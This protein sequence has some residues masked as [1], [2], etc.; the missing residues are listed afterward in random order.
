MRKNLKLKVGVLSLAAVLLFS[1]CVMVDRDFRLTRDEIFDSL[2]SLDL[3]TEVQFQIGAGLLSLGKFVTSFSNM[4]QDTRDMLREIHSLQI[5]VYQIENHRENLP[6]I[7]TK[8]ERRLK[9]RGYLP[10]VKVKAKDENVWIFVKMRHRR[11]GAMYIISLDQEEL[12]L[13]EL[14]GNLGKLIEKAVRDQGFHKKELQA[15]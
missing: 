5:G 10:I 12:V 1:G 4:N 9:Q 13:V 7:P 8:I 2:N 3:N 6:P 14:K 11:L 15:T